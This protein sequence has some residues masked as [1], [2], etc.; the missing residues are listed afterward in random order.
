[1]NNMKKNHK[2]IIAAIMALIMVVSVVYGGG[3]KIGR[4]TYAEGDEQNL[5]DFARSVEFNLPESDT[6]GVYKYKTGSTYNFEINFTEI[7]SGN[8][9]QFDTNKYTFIYQLPAELSAADFS[10][11]ENPMITQTSYG[12][13]TFNNCSYTISGGVLRLEIRFD[14]VTQ[15]NNPGTKLTV[16]E[17][18]NLFDTTEN[19]HFGLEFEATI[20]SN[21]TRI[22]FGG[23]TNPIN[24]I[25]DTSK[26]INISKSS[27]SF[28]P[29]TGEVTYTLTVASEGINNNVAINDTFGSSAFTIDPS[30]ITVSS[31]ASSSKT[32]NNQA[33]S[34][35]SLTGSLDLVNDET[36]TI[37][38][39]AKYNGELTSSGS[40]DY[41]I[42]YG[43]EGDRNNTFTVVPSDSTTTVNNTTETTDDNTNV[44]VEVKYPK[45]TKSVSGTGLDEATLTGS[46]TWTIT[47]ISYPGNSLSGK[48]ITDI[49]GD[50][51]DTATFDPDNFIITRQQFNYE[52]DY[53]MPNVGDP[54]SLDTTGLSSSS[55]GWSYTV[56][57]ETRTDGNECYKYTITYT[58]PIDASSKTSDY[59]INNTVSTD[60][61]AAD[62]T[63]IG[64][65]VTMPNDASSS[66][67]VE[68]IGNNQTR[69]T[70][71]LDIPIGGVNA[72]SEVCVEDTLP[73]LSQ[74]QDP[75]NNWQYTYLNPALVD[76][77]VGGADGIS[78]SYSSKIEG[79]KS[80]VSLTDTGFKVVFTKTEE[81]TE[82]PGFAANPAGE[83]RSVVI[84]YVTE[85]NEDWLEIMNDHKDIND[86]RKHRNTETFKIDDKSYPDDATYTSNYFVPKSISKN[87]VEGYS[88]NKSQGTTGT[89]DGDNNQIDD[90]PYFKYEIVLEGVDDSS[91]DSD[92]ILS[93]S[94]SF[95]TNLAYFKRY[96]WENDGFYGV[97]D[98]DNNQDGIK[99]T[100]ETGEPGNVTFKIAKS[101]MPKNNGSYYSKYRLV[102]YLRIK[103]KASLSNIAQKAISNINDVTTLENTATVEGFG[104]DSASFDFSYDAVSKTSTGYN[105]NDR[106]AEFTITLNPD[107]VDMDPDKDI[108]DVTDTYS[109]NL[110]I[111]FNS[112]KVY[113]DGVLDAPE[114]NNQV[115]YYASGNVLRMTVPDDKKIEIK[116][117]AKVIG[118]G[119]MTLSN[120]ASFCNQDEDWNQ[121]VNYHQG[122]SSGGSQTNISVFK[123]EDGDMTVPLKDV[124]FSLY[125]KSDDTF[126]KKFI[127]GDDGKFTIYNTDGISFDTTYYLKETGGT[128]DGYTASDISWTFTV[129][130][131]PE[132]VD[133]TYGVWKYYV[134]D[135]LTVPNEKTTMSIPVQKIWNGTAQSEAKFELYKIVNNS[136]VKV[137][138]VATLVLNAE[139][140]WKGSFD[141]I[142]RRDD[143]GETINYVVKEI[144]VPEGYICDGGKRVDG[145]SASRIDKGVVFTNTELTNGALSIT[146]SVINGSEENADKTYTVTVTAQGETT[147]INAS[148]VIVSGASSYSVAAD[149]DKKKIVF[150]F[151]KGDTVV[152]SGLPYDTYSVSEEAGE[153][154]TK[155]VVGNGAK[156][157]TA[158]AI[159][160]ADNI[161]ETIT[162]ENKYEGT[163]DSGSLT[164]RKAFAAESDTTAHKQTYYVT[165]MKDNEYY[166]A[167]GNSTGTTVTEIAVPVGDTGIT[168][169]N[170]P[171]GTYTIAEVKSGDNSAEVE[172]YELETTIKVDNESVS[173]A[174]LSETTNTA[175]AVITNKYTRQ[176]GSLEVKKIVVDDTDSSAE[177]EFNFTVYLYK[178]DTVETDTSISGTFGEMTFN[179]GVATFALKGGESKNASGLPAG[180]EYG[181]VETE[182]EGYKCEV[183]IE[184]AYASITAG[185][186]KTVTFT[187]TK[188]GKINITK[189]V[190]SNVTS[191]TDQ[192]STSIP[193]FPI[194]VTLYKDVEGKLVKDTSVSGEYGSFTFNEGVASN[195]FYDKNSMS[196][197]G[198]P[199]GTIYKITEAE[200]ENFASVI[201][202]GD[203]ETDQ[204][205]ATCGVTDVVVTN[206]RKTGDLVIKKTVENTTETT[207]LNKKFKFKIEFNKNLT[208]VFT[209]VRTKGAIKEETI[210]FDNSCVINEIEIANGETV[211]I[212]DLPAGITYTVTEREDADFVSTSS[213]AN[214]TIIPAGQEAEF[215]NIKKD[216]LVVSK[217]VDSP[218]ASDKTA[219]Y[220]FTITIY[221][222]D[223][224]T[225][226]TDVD[227]VYGEGDNA[228][229]FEG[230]IASNVELSDGESKKIKGLPEDA[231]FKVE[232]TDPGEYF[233]TYHVD[234]NGY[235]D[236]DPEPLTAYGTLTNG[237]GAARFTNV[238][239]RKEI[240]VKKIFAG[241]P[242]G[243]FPDGFQ[244][245]NSLTADVLNYLNKNGSNIIN[246]GRESN[247]YTWTISDVPLGCELK[248]TE[249]NIQVGGYSLVVNG[250]A[251][252]DNATEATVTIPVVNDQINEVVFTNAYTRKTGSL[253]VKK[254]VVG[255][256]S[257]DKNIDF[258]FTVTMQKIVDGQTVTD[259]GFE[260]EYSIITFTDGQNSV[261]STL[262]FTKGVAG[263]SLR[264]GMSVK[265]NGIP[266]GTIYKVEETAN[267]L[268]NSDSTN[269]EG[270]IAQENTTINCVFTNTHKTTSINVDKR[271]IADGEEL[272]GAI[273]Y[274]Y[275][276][277]VSN[278]K[279]PSD[280]LEVTHW[281]STTGGAKTI[282]GLE[283]GVT[284]T[285]RE[286]TAPAGYD[287]TADTVFR[288]TE[289]GKV[290]I[291]SGSAV[292]N[293]TE[294]DI[295]VIND[296][297][298]TRDVLV[299]KRDMGNGE[300][301]AGAD[302]TIYAGDVSEVQNPAVDL[303]IDNWT[304]SNEA[305]HMIEG[306]EYGKTYTLRENTAPA[307]YDV[308]ADTVFRIKP[309]GTIEILGTGTVDNSTGKEIIVI[310]DRLLNQIVIKK[311]GYVN[312]ECSENSDDEYK[313]Q[314]KPLAGVTFGLFEKDD[315]EFE[316]PVKETVSDENGVVAFG[317]ITSNKH[318]YIVKETATV[319]G[320]IL[321]DELIYVTI[322]A[323]GKVQITD[324]DGKA[325]DEVVNDLYRTD[326]E[327]LKVSEQKPDESLP[328]S[329]YVLYRKTDKGDVEIAK[330]TTDKD[331]RIKFGGVVAGNRYVI[332]EAKAPD[333]Y[334]VSEKPI[335]IG[336]EIVDDGKG[337][338]RVVTRSVDMGDG[339]E[340]KVTAY[341]DTVTGAI[342]WLEPEIICSILK[343]DEDGKALPGASL[344]IRKGSATGELIDSW[345]STE[346]AHEVAEGLLI[347]GETYYLVETAAP[348]GYDKADPIKLVVE[349]KMAAGEDETIEV[350]MTDKKSEVTTEDETETTTEV[351]T[352]TIETVTETTTETA[353]TVVKTSDETPVTGMFMMILLSLAGMVFFAAKK[354]DNNRS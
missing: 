243:K 191:D 57:A 240:T 261:E 192:V 140:S 229:T 122:S 15:T 182:V 223:G 264:G 154:T 245:T 115:H 250:N 53:Y 26:N 136:E 323:D 55:S 188:M 272:A 294:E 260:G 110:S 143:S 348:E 296:Q 34:G 237:S 178:D 62:T 207:D 236:A 214:G 269:A 48:T 101:S 36:V 174:T 104:S 224:T 41:Y 320:Y 3:K 148:D 52:N 56:P 173:T 32:I 150:N 286:D 163:V 346:T 68:Y 208:G 256:A 271:D 281:E 326:I 287:V 291:I 130:E 93:I 90:L 43:A 251:V 20:L 73:S 265:I 175:E 45:I 168:I 334:Y 155:Y 5:Q 18:K 311:L 17:A 126:I 340:G 60:R 232:E 142:P 8:K 151:K 37:T 228:V 254:T 153:Y 277:D 185:E 327:L 25:E 125:K 203:A 83:R 303:K 325:V 304:S 160:D 88:T 233:D 345:T 200:N 255:N 222:P 1:M 234:I 75:S 300:E 258:V 231:K 270:T 129:V 274:I 99:P 42:Y 241:I 79:E 197:V 282:E 66:K 165:V 137:D 218:I 248:L 89:K 252:S 202:I 331:G 344:E 51:F 253:E 113:I 332:K 268:F 219:K 216:G 312:E 86:L 335:T 246:I 324:E 67:D 279:E 50:N 124:E 171:L 213:N 206:T 106:D 80:E 54:V 35:N 204:G 58:T 27:S 146:K 13:V 352:E 321:S 96:S 244:I 249:T 162:V 184:S 128:P 263:F 221:K 238:R 84:S 299:D 227:G 63:N 145:T 82:K 12:D 111:D 289:D 310:N 11:T 288:I 314:L 105:S 257:T 133:Y 215:T 38:Y 283:Y 226:D 193:G 196:I 16:D 87:F 31:S 305:P 74:Y 14:D 92:G 23:D 225:V 97:D 152:I 322:D 103:D 317:E 313:Y 144:D 121:F 319:E 91:F 172:Y 39:K 349:E 108:L 318:E 127:T 138:G 339:K 354:K 315:T 341:I 177:A 10:G 276:G 292:Y 71:T 159:L 180:I 132:D 107:G 102:Y 316:N 337:G 170:L 347:C 242:D 342:V 293:P 6:Q 309:D 9:Q 78:V 46:A 47:A 22:S 167:S 131:N 187:N 156:T 118:Y 94:D 280:D 169:E 301:L 290:E 266:T 100:V 30:S 114:P 275:E 295:I 278:V 2:R 186:T 239:K 190:V 259:T 350:V 181:V 220:T 273:I 116:Y 338:L 98:W 195:T 81:S 198:L 284:Y 24:L 149:A 40:D 329:T 307:G 4:L 199:A 65:G 267:A 302:I 29:Q 76:T 343:V 330:A 69:W 166:N 328:D 120:T 147:T 285:L 230:G 158:V 235:A 119:E 262:T 21:T 297:L 336:V 77:V 212:E 194:T 189:N 49:F 161:S 298:K 33:V 123:Y 61:S 205:T 308:T 209:V 7:A 217:T 210:T 351:T 59:T 134:G 141:N 95:D 211:R 157:D 247:P 179:S 117:N 333:G 176:T 164:I 44:S 139:N 353:E 306:L 64:Y 28:N 19:I 72:D 201:K 109:K 85:L 183:D 112:I 70:I 135:T